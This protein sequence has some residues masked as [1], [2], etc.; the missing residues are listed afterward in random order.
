M[1]ARAVDDD[2]ALAADQAALRGRIELLERL[3]GLATTGLAR[4]LS[5]L[6]STGVLDADG[7]SSTTA[8][9]TANSTRSGRDAARMARLASNLDDLPATRRGLADGDVSVES[10]DAIVQAARDGRLGS[11]DEVD[12]QFA[13]V[14]RSSSPERLRADIRGRQ[15]AVDAAAM[16]QDENRQHARRSFRLSRTQSGT[17]R[18]S[19][20]LPDE[21]GQRFRTLLDAFERP[22]GSDTP[23]DRRRRPDVR[24]ADALSDLVGVALDHGLAPGT[25]GITRPHLSVIVDAATLSTDL[26]RLDADQPNSPDAAPMPDDRRWADLPAGDLPWGGLL[27]PQAVRRLCCDAAVSRVV[28]DGASQVLDVGRATRDWSGPQRRAVNARDRGCRGPSCD[29][30]MAWTSIHHLQ[31]WSKDGPTSVDNGLALCHHCHRL[32]HDHGWTVGLD[33]DTAVATWTAPD[34]RRVTTAPGGRPH[35]IGIG[36]SAGGMPAMT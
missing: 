20:E 31:W 24:L 13:Q 12:A 3:G 26:A 2:E 35:A 19:G 23:P 14:A 32:V 4:A 16:L 21:L 36:R 1:V 7:A 25:G 34:G 33:L 6:R 18:P 28:M 27:S 30:P 29:R 22:D 17:W 10:A 9:L 11:P 15:Q 5:R 8:W